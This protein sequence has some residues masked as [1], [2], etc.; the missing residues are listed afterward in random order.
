MLRF[1]LDTN[2]VIRGLTEP[3]NLSREQTR[4]LDDLDR[5]DHAFAISVVTL[6][7]LAIRQTVGPRR[8]KG[9]VAR[10]IASMGDGLRDPADRAIVA[11]ARVHNLKLLTSDQRI[12]DSGLVTV[13]E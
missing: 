10:E 8:I 3:K 4:I 13:V 12:I 5:H 6:F 1:L 11:T 2:A 7:E 9:D